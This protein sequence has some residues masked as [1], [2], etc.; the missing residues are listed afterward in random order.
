MT[1]IP[2]RPRDL[3]LPALVAAVVVHLLVR[4]GYGSLPSFPLAAGL[5]FAVLGAAEAIGGTALRSRIRDRTGARP[6]EPLI[7]ARAV[8]VARASAQAGAIMTGH[9][10]GCSCTSPRAARTSPLPRRHSGRGARCRRRVGA[11]RRRAV[12][13]ALLPHP[14]RP[15]RP[16]GRGRPGASVAV[17][18]LPGGARRLAVHG[19]RVPSPAH[20]RPPA[21]R[22]ARHRRRAGRVR[23]LR[24][25]RARAGQRLHRRGRRPRRGTVRTGAG[26]TGRVGVPVGGPLGARTAAH[27]AVRLPVGRLRRRAQRAAH[28]QQRRPRRRRR[29]GSG[30]R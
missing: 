28:Q 13:A 2:I 15:G 27:P 1:V 30:Q 8:L 20:P 18:T 19:G 12:A 16:E 4:L 6:V 25:R 22:R 21:A 29:A 9:G 3:V 10:S 5:P 14:R 26:R 17:L 11:G 23:R 7:A 24:A